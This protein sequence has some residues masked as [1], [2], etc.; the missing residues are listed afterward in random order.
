MLPYFRIKTLKSHTLLDIYTYLSSRYMGV[1]PPPL[2]SP[3]T[4]TR[5]HTHPRTKSGMER[6][7]QFT[8]TWQKSL[9]KLCLGVNFPLVKKKKIMMLR[10]LLAGKELD[11][12]Q[13]CRCGSVKCDSTCS[14]KFLFTYVFRRKSLA[15]RLIKNNYIYGLIALPFMKLV[16]R[17]H[18]E[19]NNF[20]RVFNRVKLCGFSII[21]YLRNLK[22]LSPGLLQYCFWIRVEVTKRWLR[23]AYITWQLNMGHYSV[24]CPMYPS[25]NTSPYRIKENR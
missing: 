17:P 15:S 20:I 22:C 5:T 9:S 11:A 1:L 10:S 16:H 8:L 18:W 3:P 21:V 13:Y 12:N 2:P 23:K 6:S 14:V 25:T 4:R 24:Y 7:V 19:W